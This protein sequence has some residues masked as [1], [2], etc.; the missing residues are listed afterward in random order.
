[1][2]LGTTIIPTI[3]FQLHTTITDKKQLADQNH[4]FAKVDQD[5]DI[6]VG[7]VIFREGVEAGAVNDDELRLCLLYTSDAADE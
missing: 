2:S 5:E 3:P 6:R 7:V 1:M 4:F